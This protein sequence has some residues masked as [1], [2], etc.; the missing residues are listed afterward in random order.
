MTSI[1]DLKNSQHNRPHQFVKYLSRKHD[2]TVLSIKDW[3]KEGQGDLNSYSSDFND[4]FEGVD[5]QYLT[6]RR[7]SPVLQEVFFKKKVEELSKE[8]FDVHL[9]YNCLITGY[10]ASKR[11]KTIF[12][13]ADDL[14]AMIRTSPQIPRFLRPFGEIMGKFFLNKDAQ[15]AD[16]FTLTTE[17]LRKTYNILD[18]KSEV[19]PNGVDTKLFKNDC[20]AKEKLGLDGFIIGYVGVLRDWVNFLPVFKA[21]KCLDDDIKLLIVGSEGRFQET[22]DLAKRCGVSNRVI[23]T[24]MVPYLEVPKYISAMDVGLI[25]FNGDKVS[26]NSLPIKLF[27]YF[28]CGKPVISSE[29]SSIRSNFSEEVFFASTSKDYAAKIDLLYKDS[30]LRRK[31]GKKCRKISENYNWEN[32][33]AKLEKIL[34]SA[35]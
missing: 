22:K 14:P 33:T 32:I 35:V 16:Y 28:A 5:F 15:Y 29:I 26:Y 24:G 7:I 18:E 12:D 1:V 25:P 30:K 6:E 8:N 19:L 4:I 2:I 23:F 27:E 9:N 13:I 17:S 3:W 10:R 31:I 34:V 11:F 21:L 20:C